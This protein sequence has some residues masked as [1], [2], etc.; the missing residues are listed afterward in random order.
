MPHKDL[1][2]ISDFDGMFVI[3]LGA[4]GA[5][6]NFLKRKK[7]GYTFISKI[8]FFIVDVLTSGGIA[9]VTYLTLM[10]YT[11]DPYIAVG[12]AG[13]LAHQGTR[14]FYILEQIV[15]QKFGVKL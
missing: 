1:N 15:V 10:G 4:W 14:A 9:V 7:D 5:I 13:I 11:E 2:N 8:G 6:M 3:L 12:V